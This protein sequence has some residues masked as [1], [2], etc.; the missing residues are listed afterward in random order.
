MGRGQATQ[1]WGIVDKRR[2]G[3]RSLVFGHGLQGGYDVIDV[4]F[5]AQSTAKGRISAK[6]NVYLPQAQIRIHYLIHTH[7][8]VED[9]RNSGKMKLR[10]MLSFF[11]LR[12]Y[13]SIHASTHPIIHPHII[14]ITIT[15]IYL[16]TI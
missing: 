8:I 11:G 7:S 9:W 13:L 5:F 10:R 15:N 1:P 4:I 6:Q 14:I 12:P 16:E 2:Q 3:E